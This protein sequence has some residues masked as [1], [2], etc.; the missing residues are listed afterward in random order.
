MLT[1]QQLEL[2]YLE[3]EVPLYNFALRWVFNSTQAEELVHEA[4]VR[5]WSKRIS[6]ELTTIKGLLYKT[7]QNLA[8][9]EIRR[10]RFREAIR[11]FDWFASD[12]QRTAEQKMI[13]QENLHELQICLDR[14]PIELREVLLLA[15][16]SDFSYA[17][18]A[19]TLGIAEGTVAS[20]KS[21]ALQLMREYIKAPLKEEKNNG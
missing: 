20:R 18:I 16:F 12:G 10:R 4:F 11:I 3:L 5:V 9:N 13:D 6:I 21:R 2:V 15:S 7:V 8:L 14:L 1:R 17:E 19:Q